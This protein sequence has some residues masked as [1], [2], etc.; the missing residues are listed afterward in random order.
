MADIK[1]ANLAKL[2]TKQA[3]RA[4]EK[5]RTYWTLGIQVDLELKFQQKDS[6]CEPR[7]LTPTHI[8]Q[9][10]ATTRASYEFL[11]GVKKLVIFEEYLQSFNI[12]IES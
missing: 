6:T 8:L 4:K 5:V 3:G 12:D 2:V 10:Y 11:A 1:T 7:L 9:V